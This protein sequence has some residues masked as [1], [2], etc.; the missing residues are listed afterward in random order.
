MTDILIKE[1]FIRFNM[2]VSIV[3]SHFQILILILLL[4]E[5]LTELQYDIHPQT[6]RHTERQNK[7]LKQHLRC[8]TIINKGDWV[9]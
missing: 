2:S 3:P 7:V 8:Y 4:L 1:V 6:D 9:Y 5:N